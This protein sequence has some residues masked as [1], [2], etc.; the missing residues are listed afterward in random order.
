[1]P[2]N[3]LVERA[4]AVVP[5][6]EEFLPLSDAVIG[7]SHIDYDKLWARSSAYA[8]LGKRIVDPGKLA[9]LIP[10]LVEK[11]QERLR[12]LFTLIVEAIEQQQRGDLATAAA[13]LIRAGEIEE[14]HRSLEKAEKIYAHA[15][16][17][18]RDLRDKEPQ[19]LALRRLG[20]VAR[21]AGRLQEAWQWYEQSY[22]LSIDQMDVP[23]Q[24]VACQ[25]LG[26]LCDDR[27][28]RDRSRA[29]YE[30]GLTLARGL[31]DPM[32]VWP[33]YTNL[34]VLARR[35]GKLDE[36]ESLLARAQEAIEAAESEIGMLFWY[37]GKGL[38][39]LERNDLTGAE[40]VY[41]DGLGRF[42]DPFWE[43]TL[44]VNLGQALLAQGRLFEAEEEAR[45]A[46]EIGVLNRLIMDL[47]DVYNLL[48]K[49][50][51]ARCDEE[52]FIF[53]E[54]ALQVCHERGLPQIKEAAIYH[55]YGLL[56]KAC[57]RSR[58]AIAY[59]EQARDIYS[60][61]GLPPELGRVEADLAALHTSSAA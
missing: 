25:G 36:A 37:N 57:G 28:Q 31:E 9:Q 13:T 21:A 22:H 60:A 10:G 40:Q 8:T 1:M 44:R 49:I 58:E 29:W 34:S 3:L 32:L 59:L 20:R 2:V 38:L 51:A 18:A 30:R 26:N 4:L 45:K 19:I 48:G 23:G 61:L 41:R 27:G 16:E 39:L 56:H 7:S 5:D 33:F 43:L 6:S 55:G 17:I 54:Q 24:V 14:A 12:D 47:V 53:Y 11:A 42:T 52:G 15:L 50:A 35:I 46:E